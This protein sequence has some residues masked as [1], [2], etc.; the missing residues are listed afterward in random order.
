MAAALAIAAARMA[1]PVVYFAWFCDGAWF[2]SDDLTYYQRSSNLFAQGVTPWE[3][4]SPNGLDLL[5]S[6]AGS[7]HVLYYWWN[8]LAFTLI[9]DAYYAPVLLNI[10]ATFVT[11]HLIGGLFEDLGFDR[12]YR[13]SAQAVVLLHWDVVTWS[14]LLNLKDSIVQL[15][16]V[17]ALA[18]SVRFIRTRSLG[19]VLTFVG[20]CLVFQTIRFYVPVLLLAAI[21][22]W[23]ATCWRHP[24]K[25]VAL[26]LACVV[27]V[28]ATLKFG[29]MLF[30]YAALADAARGIVDFSLQPRPWAIESGYSFLI[31]SSTLHWVFFAPALVGAALI[32]RE[33][34]GGRLILVYLAV[35]ICFYAL[36]QDFQGPRHRLQVSFIFA[37]L[38]F[39]GCVRALSHYMPSASEAA[40]RQG[41]VAPIA[42]R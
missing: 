32:W 12:F 23:A 17:A 35:V 5:G 3:L 19:S 36:A 4:L 26:A 38:Q 21:G 29:D 40:I 42:A 33:S 41:A 1:V 31:L 7:D 20:V 27:G 30:D 8:L 25:F 39:H 18:A 15:L 14:S 28:K 37:W 11:A 16:T 10:G 9:G 34:V 6:V 22:F 2:V 24:L 13:V